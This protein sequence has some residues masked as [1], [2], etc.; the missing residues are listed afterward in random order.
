MKTCGD[1]GGM[2]YKGKPCQK[3]SGAL[4]AQHAE[5]A[6]EHT[7]L[8][9]DFLEVYEGGQKTGTYQRQWDTLRD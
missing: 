6:D 5:I 4:C 3:R 2:T 8:K 7:Q 1:F 9:A